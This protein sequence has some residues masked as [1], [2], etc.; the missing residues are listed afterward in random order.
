MRMTINLSGGLIEQL[1]KIHHKEFFER[2]RVLVKSGQVELLQTP[3]YHHLLPLVSKQMAERQIEQNREL[4]WRT[5]KVKPGRGLFAPE[6][7]VDGSVLTLANES[8]WYILVDQTAVEAKINYDKIRTNPIGE[9]NGTT[10]VVNSRVL[11]DIVR[12]YPRR[13]MGGALE[14]F[15]EQRTAEDGGIVTVVDVEL[16]G[17]HYQERLEVL[18]QLIK[19]ELFK[20]VT[21]QELLEKTPPVEIKKFVASSWQYP[22][23]KGRHKAFALW[24]NKHNML[25]QAYLS[26]AKYANNLY[27]YSI[28]KCSEEAKMQATAHLDKGYSSCNFYWLSNQPWWHPDLVQKGAEQLVRCIRTLPISF[29][30]KRKGERMYFSLCQNIWLYHWSGKVDKQYKWYDKKREELLAKLPMLE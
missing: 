28:H 26:L 20:F 12:A 2:L 18:K 23:A 6:L 22:I 30:Q 14:K 13:L 17:H 4:L 10:L 7:A 29:A 1:E 11:C 19:S 25:Q 8:G 16:F 24:I 21:A 15:V 3:A 27:T 5:M 9:K